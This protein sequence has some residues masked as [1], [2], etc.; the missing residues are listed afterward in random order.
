MMR[1]VDLFE[2]RFLCI[3]DGGN[4]LEKFWISKG[5]VLAQEGFFKFKFGIIELCFNF[6]VFLNGCNAIRLSIAGF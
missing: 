4:V 1:V 5:V 6:D 2:M 3:Y